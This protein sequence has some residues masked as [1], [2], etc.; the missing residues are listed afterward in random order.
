MEE[1]A[2]IYLDETVSSVG[3]G[4]VILKMIDMAS[5][6]EELAK[7]LAIF[8]DM[9]RDSWEASEEMERIRESALFRGSSSTLK[10]LQRW[11]RAP[12][13]DTETEDGSIGRRY[14]CKD[15]TRRSRYQ[16]GQTKVG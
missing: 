7:T 9:L 2:P 12:R 13:G 10:I 14:M 16:N 1:A 4:T 8:R 15:L 6:S 5:T 3:G 11:F